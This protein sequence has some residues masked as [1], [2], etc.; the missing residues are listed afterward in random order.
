MANN[1]SNSK[2]DMTGTSKTLI[3]TSGV[4]KNL[5]LVVC[6]G[7][8]QIEGG[9]NFQGIIMTDGKITLQPKACLEA[10]PVEAAKIFQQQIDD[11]AG[12]IK[13]QD[14]FWM[15]DQYVLG[16]TTDTSQNANKDYTTY[17]L[18]DCVTYRNWKKE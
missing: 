9:V 10:A 7:D 2:Y 1:A 6:T 12:N 8:V 18:A 3:V 14:F 4:A 5:R 15:G 17:D 16:N 13:A 11:G